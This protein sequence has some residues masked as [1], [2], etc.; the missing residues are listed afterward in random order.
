MPSMMFKVGDVIEIRKSKEAGRPG[1]DGTY[2]VERVERSGR[3]YVLS[4]LVFRGKA[5]I[6][7]TSMKWIEESWMKKVKAQFLGNLG[8]VLRQWKQEVETSA[9]KEYPQVARGT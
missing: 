7:D 4:T 9:V 8:V 5:F 3:E 6:I 1:L 2:L